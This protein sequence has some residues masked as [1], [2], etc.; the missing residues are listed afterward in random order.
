MHPPALLVYVIKGFFPNNSF[1][2][3]HRLNDGTLQIYF[4]LPVRAE[5]QW[6][7]L[8]FFWGC[9]VFV[10]WLPLPPFL[11][12]SLTMKSGGFVEVQ[13]T[14]SYGKFQKSETCSLTEGR[15]EVL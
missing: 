6:V 1:M 11:S 10:F 12:H 7:F 3:D 15:R 8:F 13:Q 9:F 5:V 4:M 14:N 2:H